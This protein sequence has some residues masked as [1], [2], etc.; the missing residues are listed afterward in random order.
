MQSV[1]CDDT[2]YNE[3]KMFSFNF[4]T[5]DKDTYF[6]DER[7]FFEMCG[8]EYC[9]KKGRIHYTLDRV[10][11]LGSNSDFLQRSVETAFCK[12][13]DFTCRERRCT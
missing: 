2:A 10:Y 6:G 4:Q 11:H 12:C 8:E 13:L 3:S 7:M 5:N 9:S 1:K